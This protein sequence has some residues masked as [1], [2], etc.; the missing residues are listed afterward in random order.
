MN[1]GES[2]DLNKVIAALGSTPLDDNHD[3]VLNQAA[4]ALE[5]LSQRANKALAAGPL[6]TTESARALLAG[7]RLL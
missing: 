6:L 3:D 2:T 7:G 1:I 4:A 5:R